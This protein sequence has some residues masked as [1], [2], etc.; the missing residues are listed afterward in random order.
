MPRTNNNFYNYK[1]EITE[2]GIVRYTQNYRN[3]KEMLEDLVGNFK[4]KPTTIQSRCSE[5]RRN[6]I[7][8]DGLR[9]IRI[10]IPVV[11]H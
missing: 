9:I 5:T 11:N 8:G 10:K 6:R 2:K 7:G 4:Y 1:S 3:M